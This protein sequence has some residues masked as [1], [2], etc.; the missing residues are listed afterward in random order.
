MAQ[1]DEVAAGDEG[2]RQD[3][4]GGEAGLLFLQEFMDVEDG[5]RG[6]AVEP[7]QFELVFEEGGSQQA[8]ELGCAHFGGIGQAHVAGDD[9]ADVVGERVR[10]AQPLQNGAGHV[11]AD[12]GVAF[13][14]PARGA[15]GE[16]D[17]RGGGRLADVVQQ[18]GER[19]PQRRV[20]RQ[21]VEHELRMREDI[22][23]GVE[24]GGLFDAGQSFDFGQD[25]LEQSGVAQELEGFA[26]FPGL[27]QEAEQL[28]ADALGADAADL[29]REGPEGG[30]GGGFDGEAERG[31]EAHGAQQ[32]QVVLGEAHRRVADGANDSGLEIR[33]AVDVIADF[34][35]GRIE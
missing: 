34:A 33:L 4:L 25:C 8:A 26:G 2:G 13:E 30:K 1:G 27:G 7:V 19:E 3:G 12:G 20:R 35:G 9:G 16:R 18:D 29:R 31:G 6:E 14:A 5:V 17:Q 11:G 22:A 10:G 28:V 15:V 21:R 32:A 24:F 23:L